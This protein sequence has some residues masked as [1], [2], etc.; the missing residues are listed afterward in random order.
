MREPNLKPGLRI[1]I[2]IL[3]HPQRHY[4]SRIEAL[5]PKSIAIMFPVSLD[6]AAVDIQAGMKC[7]IAFSIEAGTYAFDTKITNIHSGASPSLM[8]TRPK[9]FYNWKRQ[10]LRLD[11]GVWVRYA[12][13]PR[14]EMGERID[15]PIRAYT[16]TVNISGGGLLIHPSESLSIGATLELE[17]DIPTDAEPVLAIGRVAH[18]S[19]HGYGVEFLLID[20]TDRDK[21]VR[22]IFEKERQS[23]HTTKT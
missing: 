8:V 11:T 3:S 21:L 14:E 10:H 16:Q 7:R 5:H 20:D 13:V 15:Q 9:A 18:I 23:R 6:D 1:Q 12:V 17:I 4:L 19:T 2:E 22:Y